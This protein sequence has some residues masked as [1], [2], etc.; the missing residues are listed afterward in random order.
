MV[1]ET[2][3]LCVTSPVLCQQQACL[4][5]RDLPLHRIC[6][7]NCIFARRQLARKGKFSDNLFSFTALPKHTNTHTRLSGRYPIIFYS[8]ISPKTPVQRTQQPDSTNDIFIAQNTAKHNT[9][10]ARYVGAS[11]MYVHT[12]THTHTHTHILLQ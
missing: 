9:H 5:P 1:V 3:K 11:Y 7:T 8:H 12:H 4:L 10:F 6:H 2:L